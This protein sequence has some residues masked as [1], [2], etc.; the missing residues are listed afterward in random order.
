M[1][2]VT[3]VKDKK[4]LSVSELRFSNNYELTRV[5]KETQGTPT[6]IMLSGKAS[7]ARSAQFITMSQRVNIG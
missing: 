2:E 5:C 1:E 7:Q 6:S 3:W 4:T